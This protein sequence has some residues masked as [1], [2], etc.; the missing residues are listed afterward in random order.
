MR[1][2]SLHPDPIAAVEP[3]PGLLTDAL[4]L[5]PRGLELDGVPLADVARRHG[6]PVYVYGA[7][8]LRRRLAELRAALA[9]TGAA[10][11]IHYAMRGCRFAPVLELVRQQ[12]DIGIDACSPR[13]VLRA[14][15]AGFAPEEI[16]VTASMLSNRDLRHLAGRGVRLN[17]DSPSALRRWAAICGPGRTAGLSI[18]AGA[19][20][21][22]PEVALGAAAH[23][24]SM[25]VPVDRLHMH[26][27]GDLD[28]GAA[29]QLAASFARL[30][31]LAQAIPTVRT[32]HVSGG[33]GW[34]GH[35]VGDG[36][37]GQPEDEPLTLALWA[38]LLRVHLAPTGCVLACDP[39]AFFA[40]SS[41]VLLADASAVEARPGK[42][43]PRLDAGGPMAVYPAGACGARTASG[44]SLRG[45]PAEVLV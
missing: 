21:F 30:S 32:L 37:A 16:S 1:D 35:P 38:D 40:A 15:A 2:Q 9:S 44:P 39:G 5:G 12:R 26:A 29:T 33:I 41:G 27:G 6:T 11:R 43:L 4:V 20:G 28:A 42:R 13:E 36:G 25:G 14:I 23:V 18:A 19:F 24:A 7:A 17:V 10:F 3:A 45:A 8:T 22:A 31:A 34:R